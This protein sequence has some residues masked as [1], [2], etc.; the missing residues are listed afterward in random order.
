[1][2]P[3]QP[4]SLPQTA[5]RAEWALPMQAFII[6]DPGPDVPRIR[7]ALSGAGYDCPPTHVVSPDQVAAALAGKPDLLVMALGLDPERALAVVGQLSANGCPLLVVGST[8]DSRLVLRALRA[9]A[10]DFVD[11]RE[12]ENDLASALSRVH[13]GSGRH[14]EPARTIA[15]L[16]PSG[17]SGASTL[18]V[19]VASVYADLHKSALLIDLKLYNGDLAA[20]LDVRPTHTLAELCQNSGQMDRTMFERSLVRHPSG[21]ALLAPPRLYP[22]IPLV[23]ADGVRQI[24]N[25]ARSSFPYVVIDLDNTFAPEQVQA[26][27]LADVIVLVLRLD[28]ATLRNAKRTLD[29]LDQLGIGRDKVRVVVNRHGQAK[30][31]PM[32]KAE[33]ALGVK[34]AYF[35]PEDQKTVNRANNNGV[36]VVRESPSARVS[37][38]LVNLA[39]GVN[40]RKHS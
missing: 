17:G 35:I 20:L 14:V 9:G 26:L 11:E 27:R 23:T 36:P 30:E 39:A 33:L 31:I 3:L 29:Y 8:A 13:V 1:M 12:L 38:S 2:T 7:G 34:I 40:G 25:L 18:A 21:V 19:N 10:A 15:V 22:D 28:F 37:K 5:S 16:S 32:E 6:S 24:I 4:T